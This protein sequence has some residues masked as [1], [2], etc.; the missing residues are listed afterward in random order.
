MKYVP[1]QNII[2]DFRS[3]KIVK[4]HSKKKIVLTNPLI[5]LDINKNKKSIKIKR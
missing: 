5:K 4:I 2:E 1:Q 3:K